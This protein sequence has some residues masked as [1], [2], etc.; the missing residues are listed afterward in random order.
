MENAIRQL[1]DLHQLE[2]LLLRL[3]RQTA[4]NAAALR[5]AKFDLR[6][7]KVAEAEYAGSFRSFRDKLTGKQEEKETGLRHAVQQAEAALTSAQQTRKRL[8][9]QLPEARAR[10]EA[11]PSRD[12]LREQAD[13]DTLLEWNRLEALYC[14]EAVLPLLEANREL[15]IERR[16]QFNGSYAGQLKTRQTLAEIYTAP[17]AAGEA[18]KPYILR[19][20]E[21]LDTLGIPFPVPEYWENPTAFLSYATKY[22]RMD[23]INTAIAQVE[24]TQQLL[25]GLRKQLEE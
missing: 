12:A 18:C 13:P 16:N 24:A 21:A 8:E 23:R 10:L 1:Q 14:M 3:Q 22:T 9:L 2:L 4:E 15:L 5:Q 11:L 20:K 6:E 25:P 19:L 7:A 17:E